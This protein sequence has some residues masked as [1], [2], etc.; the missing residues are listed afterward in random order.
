MADPF[1]A[2]IRAFP[3]N[4]PPKDWARCD[5]QLMPISQNTPLFALLGTNYGGDGQSTFA[6][7]DL[8][9]RAPMHAG[10]GPGLS[11]RDL[12]EQ[13]GSETATLT[14][15][16]I[17]PHTHPLRGSTQLADRRYP[18]GHVP[19]APAEPAYATGP[20]TP[21]AAEAVS[22]GGGGQPHTNLQ[23]YLTVQFCIAL[24]GIFPQRW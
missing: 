15:A 22:P 1:I 24:V 12:G 16:E 9:G 7:P 14:E 20:A 18:A 19:A 11:Y 5:G 8:Q 10:Q 23:P 6:L 3:F 4:F 2:E 21:M 13:G 17:P